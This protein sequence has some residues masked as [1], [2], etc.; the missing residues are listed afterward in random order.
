MTNHPTQ[1]IEQDPLTELTYGKLGGIP[2]RSL[3]QLTKLIGEVGDIQKMPEPTQEQIH[4]LEGYMAFA[5]QVAEG[6]HAA[7]IT[8][9]GTGDLQIIN[10]GELNGF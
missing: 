3:N 4:F 5:R 7:R 1:S 9:D 2:I 10:L 8:T 6:T